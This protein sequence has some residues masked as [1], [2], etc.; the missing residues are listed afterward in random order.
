MS[1]C[2]I[3]HKRKAKYVCS[4]CGRKVCEDCF[5]TDSWLCVDCLKRNIGIRKEE[6]WEPISKIPLTIKI[7]LIGFIT[8]FI[9][10]MILMAASLQG[11]SDISGGIII[12][13]FL[14]IPL[15]IGKGIG[16]ITIIIIGIIAALIFLAP[17]ILWWIWRRNIQP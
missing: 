9:G 15:I 10:A 6:L 4:E 14:P 5:D 8:T 2:E 17:M 13:P 1:I 3:C 7:I 11:V 12:F 16:G